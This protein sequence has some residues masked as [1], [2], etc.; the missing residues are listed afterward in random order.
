MSRRHA[1]YGKGALPDVASANMASRLQPMAPSGSAPLGP[2]AA[3]P[4]TNLPM[5]PNASCDR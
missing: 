4:H 1:S 5:S 2:K 3:L